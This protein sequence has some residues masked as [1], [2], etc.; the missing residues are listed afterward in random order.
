M[1]NENKRVIDC[2]LKELREYLELSQKEKIDDLL[3]E[4]LGYIKTTDIKTN[5]E[6]CKILDISKATLY[7][8]YEQGCPRESVSEGSLRAI[9]E[10]RRKGVT[11]AY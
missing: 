10:W 3:I 11:R 5:A 2:T 8:Y 4:I 1:I 7:K 9:M 6:I